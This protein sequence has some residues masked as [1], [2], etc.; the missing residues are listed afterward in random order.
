MGTGAGERRNA[1]SGQGYFDFLVRW[2]T[3]FVVLMLA[4]IK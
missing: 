3:E 4:E 2:H 1:G